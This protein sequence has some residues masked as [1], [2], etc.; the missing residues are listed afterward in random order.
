M[1]SLATLGVAEREGFAARTSWSA[2]PGFPAPTRSA[3]S[4]CLVSTSHPRSI[5]RRVADGR[6]IRY[7][8]PDPVAEYIAAEGL[9]A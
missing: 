1:L 5:R 8:V 7:L 4:T 6:P 2:S 9:Y 3:F